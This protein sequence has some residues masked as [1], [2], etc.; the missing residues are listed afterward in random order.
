MGAFGAVHVMCCLSG[1]KVSVWDIES[2]AQP[3]GYSV[4]LLFDPILILFEFAPQHKKEHL[5]NFAIEV[6]K[7]RETC[8]ASPKTQI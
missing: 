3:F 7:K 6:A 2:N 1:I 8:G 4:W 5:R